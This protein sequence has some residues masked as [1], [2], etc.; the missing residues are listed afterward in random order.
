MELLVSPRHQKILIS[1]TDRKDF[2][3]QLRCSESKAISNTIAPAV[4]IE[5]LQDT[6]AYGS[7]LIRDA[8]RKYDRLR[9]GDHLGLESH[10]GILPPTG[11]LWTSFQSVL[12]G[13]HAGVEIA[14]ESHT[15]LLKQYGL[16]DDE[17]QLRASRPLRSSCCAQG[18]VIDD[19]FTVGVENKTT[20]VVIAVEEGKVIGAQVNA[21][22]RAMNLGIATVASPPEKRLGLSHL[23]LLLCNLGYTTDS[24]HLCLIGGWVSA[25]GYRRSLM[26]LLNKAF[27]LVSLEG[28]DSNNPKIIHLPRSVAEE[29]VLI[30]V[31]MP[32]MVCDLTAP[33]HD[34]IYCSDASNDR[35]AVL[36]SKIRPELAEI[37]W[38]TGRSKGSYTRLLSPS[39][40][41]LRRLESIEETADGPKVVDPSRPLAYQFE[42]LVPPRFHVS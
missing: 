5:L 20:K 12:Q 6:K 19:F 21:S 34:Q 41:L 40:V 31:L 32:F 27:N 10:D 9:E 39:E 14:T 3:H 11:H 18:L 28:F 36:V 26:S 8:R 13:D 24:L 4:P 25:L 23:T 35:G 7:Y 15:F 42:F 37:L 33:F 2:Y 22:R 1:I 29:L 17:S 38:K 16:L 30:S